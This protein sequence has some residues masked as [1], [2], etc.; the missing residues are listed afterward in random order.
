MTIKAY[1]NREISKVVFSGNPTAL[2]VWLKKRN[3]RTKILAA[4]PKAYVGIF[5]QIPEMGE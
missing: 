4:L 2:S 1:G 5:A 3:D